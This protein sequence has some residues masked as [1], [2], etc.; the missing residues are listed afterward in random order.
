MIFSLFYFIYKYVF[1]NSDSY[2]HELW[3][4]YEILNTK[5]DNYDS[6]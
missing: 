4:F 1:D 3:F 6:Y 2:T 5:F